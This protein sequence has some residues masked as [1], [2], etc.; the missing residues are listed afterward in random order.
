MH[1]G[2]EF[3]QCEAGIHYQGIVMFCSH[4]AG[5][6]T[7][8]LQG[9]TAWAILTVQII[10]INVSLN[11]QVHGGNVKIHQHGDHLHLSA[12]SFHIIPL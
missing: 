2:R 8:S 6:V 9:F 7:Y 12:E 4:L 3:V 1:E 5:D 10:Q 11:L